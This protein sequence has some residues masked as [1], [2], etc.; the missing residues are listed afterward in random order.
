MSLVD[1]LIDVVGRQ[2]SAEAV[3]RRQHGQVF[4]VHDER[5]LARSVVAIRSLALSDSRTC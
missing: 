5:M 3:D 4:E 2:V 1:E